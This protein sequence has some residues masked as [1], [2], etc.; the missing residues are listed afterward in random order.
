M[1]GL[2]LGNSRARIPTNEKLFD[3][4]RE[5]GVSKASCCGYLTNG[6]GY[7]FSA[8]IFRYPDFKST[9]HDLLPRATLS[10]NGI[11]L[12]FCT[13]LGRQ[14]AKVKCSGRNTEICS[15]KSQTTFTTLSADPTNMATQDFITWERSAF[16][17]DFER[18]NLYF[19]HS[20]QKSTDKQQQ[21]QHFSMPT[22]RFV[23]SPHGT[24][25]R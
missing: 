22:F 1:R 13:N 2:P 23:I 14:P 5:L 9:P 20:I 19:L 10:M 4:T 25:K 12:F 24:A 16:A 11:G 8:L 3:Q 7:L 21:W 18:M 15:I 17:S 6:M